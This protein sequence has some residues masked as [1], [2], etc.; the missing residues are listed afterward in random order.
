MDDFMKQDFTVTKIDLACYVRAGTGALVHKNRGSH[1]LALFLG[2]ERTIC[3]DNA[4]LK[5]TKNMI[6]YF[7]KG[8]NYTVKE[9]E[10]SDCYAINF[11]LPEHIHF[12]PFA[13]PV[14]NSNGYLENFRTAQ[15]IWARKN[16]GYLSKVRSELYDILFKMQTEYDLP[17][18]SRSVIQPALD[19]IHGYYYKESISIQMLADLCGISTVHLRNLFIR[20]FAIP[21]V[22]YIN[23]L[24]MSR[25]KELL[26]SGLYTVSETCFLSG[27]QDES[28]F[29]REFKKHFG[30]SP[31]EYLKA[32]RSE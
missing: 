15:K 3:F 13:L 16:V 26:V 27:Y 30:V 1:G 5:V 8:S 28:Y 32:S 17:Y 23:S 6:V 12:D 22:K 9:K 11:Q 25:A 29:S 19:H 24:K 4:R 14:K 2:G 20:L 31:K 21:P 18:C 7:P 10:S